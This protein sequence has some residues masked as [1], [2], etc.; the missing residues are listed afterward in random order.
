MFM[1]FSA[2]YPALVVKASGLAAGK[3]VIIA[4]SKEEACDVVKSMLDQKSF[5]VS[6]EVILRLQILSRIL[7]IVWIISFMRHFI[8]LLKSSE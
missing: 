5:G 6:G 8:I 7:Y 3:G 2:P 4:K 1:C